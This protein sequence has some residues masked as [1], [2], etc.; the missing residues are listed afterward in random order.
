MWKKITAIKKE[1]PFQ[2]FPDS[3]WPSTSALRISDN[4]TKVSDKINEENGIK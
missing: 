1:T 2:A 3:Q 4:I